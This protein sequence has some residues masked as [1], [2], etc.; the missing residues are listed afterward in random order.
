MEKFYLW[1]LLSGR[2]SH[3]LCWSDS[4]KINGMAWW[5]MG[6]SFTHKRACAH[7]HTQVVNTSWKE[8]TFYDLCAPLDLELLSS[9]T[10]IPQNGLPVCQ[11]M[12][13][14]TRIQ[15]NTNTQEHNRHSSAVL[16]P[17]CMLHYV[18]FVGYPSNSK[19]YCCSQCLKGVM[20]AWQLSR[21]KHFYKA[22]ALV[23]SHFWKVKNL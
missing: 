13:T 18:A 19:S 7:T 5:L 14:V 2:C 12:V 16:R 4:W 21:P 17:G 23:L 15:I 10:V 20:P 22:E 11:V 8:R 1:C 3:F 6:L 9:L